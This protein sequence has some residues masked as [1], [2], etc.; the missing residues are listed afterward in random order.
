MQA[1]WHYIAYGV[2]M[3]NHYYRGLKDTGKSVNVEEFILERVEERHVEEMNI[4][5]AEPSDNDQDEDFKDDT[6][7]EEKEEMFSPEDI[8]SFKKTWEEFGIKI[9]NEMENG[10][11]NQEL[12]KSIESVTKI[13]KKSMKSKTNTLINQLIWF[14]KYKKKTCKG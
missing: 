14:G 6:D 3:P 4:S 8:A 11:T 2:T 12:K 9:V 5:S 1:M 7:E 10:N 13:M